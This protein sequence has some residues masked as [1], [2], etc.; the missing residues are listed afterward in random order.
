LFVSVTTVKAHLQRVF[1]KLNVSRRSQLH[2]VLLSDGAWNGLPSSAIAFQDY[3]NV[4][5]EP[6]DIICYTKEGFFVTTVP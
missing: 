3:G 4:P 2:D 1:R 6:V 5:D